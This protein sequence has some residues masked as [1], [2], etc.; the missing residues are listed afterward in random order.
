MKIVSFCRFIF[1]IA[2]LFPFSFAY[3][4]KEE[5]PDVIPPGARGNISQI[6]S[7]ISQIRPNISSLVN[8]VSEQ[9]SRTSSVS[10]EINQIAKK[11]GNIKLTESDSEVRLELLSDILF[12][13]D[14]W[15]IRPTAEKTL[16]YVGEIISKYPKSKT[17]LEGHT[18][19]KGDDNYNLKL[20]KKRADSVK[21]WLVKNSSLSGASLVAV[22]YGEKKPVAPNA[23]PNGEDN[24]EG[25][26]KNRRVEIVIQK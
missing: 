1:L 6:S 8:K 19:S 4:Q 13:F 2:V 22:G 25:R 3:A 24:P 23:L 18:D 15:N 17:V 20:S 11:D 5:M 7:S 9:N 12:D 26:Q 16:R 10:L 21:Q 14:K